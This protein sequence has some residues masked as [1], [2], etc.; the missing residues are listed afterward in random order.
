MMSVDQSYESL[1]ARGRLAD[2]KTGA[3]LRIAK[4]SGGKVLFSDLADAKALAAKGPT[5][6]FF[7]ADW[8]PSCQ[9]DLR[10]INA[11]GKRLSGAT[12]VVVDY[13]KAADLKAR[14]AVTV[15]DT[16]VLIDK[17]GA[18]LSA[19]NG[20]GVDGILDHLKSM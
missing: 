13:D 6:L 7:A 9:A 12:V 5:L 2:S 3:S 4:G 16:F 20:G 10:D 1:K 17:T 11:N 8:C 18:K 19:W 14:Y 15:Q